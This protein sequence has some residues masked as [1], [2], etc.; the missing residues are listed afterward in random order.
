MVSVGTSE[1]VG[2]RLCVGDDENAN[3]G[4]SEGISERNVFKFETGVLS[5]KVRPNCPVGG[6]TAVSVGGDDGEADDVGSSLSVDG[7][8][9]GHFDGTFE[10]HCDGRNEG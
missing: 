8:C 7:Y 5:K 3:E 10:G 2:G 6:S 1:K 4:L 9:D